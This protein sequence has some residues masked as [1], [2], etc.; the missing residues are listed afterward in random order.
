MKSE[1]PR[2]FTDSQST[3]ERL[4]PHREMS[5]LQWPSGGTKVFAV[6]GDPVEHSLSPVLLN[7][8][9]TA[10]EL[11]A[12]YVALR[13]SAEDLEGAV[14]GVRSMGF[15][16][17]SVTMPHKERIIGHLD[18]VTERAKTLNSVNCIFW[19]GG[20]LVGDST[21][22]PALV[23]SLEAEM[24]KTVA[25]RSVVVLGTGGAARAIILAL[26]EAGVGKVIVVGRSPETVASLVV[27]GGPCV[28]AGTLLD[29]ANVEIVVN[30]TSVGM[31]GT[32]GE[33]RTLVPAE[34]ITSS[35]FVYDII[36]HPLMTPLLR[37]ALAAGAGV[38]NGIGMLVHQAARA[39]QI[40]T[41]KT[42]PLEA[43][44]QSVRSSPRF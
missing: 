11:D 34:L 30:A 2:Q 39:F 3:F 7:A 36:Y 9:F 26:A 1:F 17:V 44:F 24:G 42:A 13:I 28:R 35:H 32:T 14:L 43:M 31:A 12:V 16:G 40:W 41:R 19:D 4:I 29:V 33:G 20:E 38:S 18:R 23:S 27:L 6:F 25:E 15:G 21:D 8:A 22:G 5:A 10:T 37:D